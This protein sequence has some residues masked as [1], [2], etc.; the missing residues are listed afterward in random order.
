MKVGDLIKRKNI[1]RHERWGLGIVVSL[2]LDQRSRCGRSA[3]ILYPHTGCQYDIAVA[4][5]EVVSESR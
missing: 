4:L 2:Q 1:I 3:T 5:I